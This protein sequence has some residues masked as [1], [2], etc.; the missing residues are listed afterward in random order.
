VGEDGQ[1]S[2]RVV[3]SLAAALGLVLVLAVGL[4]RP[5]YTVGGTEV[6][7]PD[8]SFST[9]AQGL[10]DEERDPCTAQ[11]QERLFAVAASLMGLV[12]ISGLLTRRRD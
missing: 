2:S 8:R 4:S 11:A 3:L 5:S 6:T 10:L 7:C 12:L 1:V 9:A